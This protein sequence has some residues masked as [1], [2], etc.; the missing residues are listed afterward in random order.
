MYYI[1]AA[2]LSVLVA[3]GFGLMGLICGPGNSPDSVSYQGCWRL[4]AFGDIRMFCGGARPS[5]ALWPLKRPRLPNETRI[6]TLLKSGTE[7]VKIAYVKRTPSYY[8]NQCMC[9]KRRSDISQ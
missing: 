2:R 7:V 3:T 4:V 5:L 8:P 1:K 6:A 9:R